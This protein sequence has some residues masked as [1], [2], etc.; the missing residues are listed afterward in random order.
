[1]KIITNNQP[2]PLLRW[3]DLTDKEH[4][5]FDWLETED[6]KVSS[7]FFRYKGQ[8]YCLGEFL[9]V[10]PSGELSDWDGLHATSAFS[11]ILVKLIRGLDDEVVVGYCYS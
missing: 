1:M 2:R 6:D 4:L 9:S 7:E 10:D 3:G 5:E 11:G 8:V